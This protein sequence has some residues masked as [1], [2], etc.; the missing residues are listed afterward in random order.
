MRP[1]KEDMAVDL[2]APP[3]YSV[4][5]AAAYLAHV[6]QK[7]CGTRNGETALYWHIISVVTQHAKES[8][9]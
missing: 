8:N 1:T 3:S 9:K 7:D 5:N 6:V 2:P 4:Q